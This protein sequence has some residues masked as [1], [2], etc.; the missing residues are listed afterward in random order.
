MHCLVMTIFD[1]CLYITAASCFK[2]TATT[3]IVHNTLP[4]PMAC[5]R[6][7]TAWPEA[8]T[9]G[10]M[11]KHEWALSHQKHMYKAQHYALF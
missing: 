6:H 11:F 10:R 1:R 8:T 7:N 3:S 5:V 9:S 2:L 4:W